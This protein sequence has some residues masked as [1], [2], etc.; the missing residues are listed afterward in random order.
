MSPLM[1]GTSRTCPRELEEIYNRRPVFYVSILLVHHV[2]AR[3]RATRGPFGAC[4]LMELSCILHA[5]TMTKLA[6]DQPRQYVVRTR[7]KNHPLFLRRDCRA[8]S[9][10]TSS[11][12]EGNKKSSAPP[13]P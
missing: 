4:V 2:S 5:H 7:K 8:N 13:R 11:K 6:T 1:V 9:K 10:I 3:T 12:M